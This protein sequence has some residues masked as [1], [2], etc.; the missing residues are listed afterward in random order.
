MVWQEVLQMYMTELP[1]MKYAA[2]T[3]KQSKFL[4]RCVT[5]GYYY[6]LLIL[7]PPLAY[8]ASL[9]IMLIIIYFVSFW[10]KS[11]LVPYVN[12]HGTS[13]LKGARNFHSWIAY[14]CRKYR[15]LLLKSGSVQNSGKVCLLGELGLMI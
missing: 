2:N 11:T 13:K 1:G 12:V 10:K 4:E 6:F 8:S 5:N 9:L 3:G 15:T 7:I 14:V